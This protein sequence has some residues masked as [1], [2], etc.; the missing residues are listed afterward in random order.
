MESWY[1]V[2]AKSFEILAPTLG[3]EKE[4]GKKENQRKTI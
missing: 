1:R 2:S 3:K 4:K